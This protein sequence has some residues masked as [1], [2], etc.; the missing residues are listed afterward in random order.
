M[1]IKT[2]NFIHYN[3]A[4]AGGFF[5]G[6]AVC[7][8]GE[9]FGNAQTLNLISIVYNIFFCDF[10]KLWL[11]I[12]AALLYFLGFMLAVLIPKIFKVRTELISILID[13]AAFIIL[14]FLPTHIPFLISL[15]PIFFASAFQWT[16]FEY[17]EGYS[18]STI[19][20]SNNYRQFTTSLIEY[21]IDKD[22]SRLIKTRIFGI[23]LLCFHIGVAFA[24]VGTI[25]IGRFSSLLGILVLIPAAVLIIRK[26]IKGKN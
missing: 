9:I 20:S 22:K 3:M 25:L 24:C 21:L 4:L 19:F 17:I 1:R 23:T 15:Y 14:A 26:R 18:S 8:L 12:A 5:G 7:N 10:E 2:D 11:R 16:A 6:F 13:A